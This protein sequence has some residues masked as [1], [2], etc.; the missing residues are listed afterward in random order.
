MM[1]ANERAFRIDDL[2]NNFTHSFQ[3]G[4]RTWKPRERKNTSNGFAVV[5]CGKSGSRPYLV[6][7]REWAFSDFRI[8][9]SL[10]IYIRL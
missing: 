9:N 6:F 5:H 7:I 1:L 4:F 10:I 8:I 2:A 3:F